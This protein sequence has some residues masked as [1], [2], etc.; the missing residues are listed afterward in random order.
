MKILFES[1]LTINREVKKLISK[2]A[3]SSFSTTN[4]QGDNA[5][6]CTSLFSDHLIDPNE[7]NRMFLLY[8][9]KQLFNWAE[10]NLHGPD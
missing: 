8:M 2:D 6:Y 1:A 5:N 3:L 9:G 4:Y 7:S 10:K